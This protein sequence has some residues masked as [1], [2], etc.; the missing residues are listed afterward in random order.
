MHFQRDGS[1]KNASSFRHN[2]TPLW[3]EFFLGLPD[4]TICAEIRQANNK[5]PVKNL[6]F[7]LS[8]DESALCYKTLSYVQVK[9]WTETIVDCVADSTKA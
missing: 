2:F 7:M 1:T 9:N 4:D 5:V 3:A 8:S 6:K